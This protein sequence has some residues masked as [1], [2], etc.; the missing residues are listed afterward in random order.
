[1]TRIFVALG[2]ATLLAGCGAD[3]APLRPQPGEDVG[4]QADPN[5]TVAPSENAG[6]VPGAVS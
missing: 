3:G 5:D 4:D 2:L 1:M 6:E